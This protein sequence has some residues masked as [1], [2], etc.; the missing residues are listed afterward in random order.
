M[1]AV[2]TSPEAGRIL[3][4]SARTVQRMADAD[5]LPTIGKLSGP[6]GAYLFD[7]EAIE[8][9]AAEAQAS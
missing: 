4:K 9:L 7:R 5:E 8:A 6:N 1:P 2:I 3:G